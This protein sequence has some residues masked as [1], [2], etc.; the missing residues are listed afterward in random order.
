M[1][2]NVPWDHVIWPLKTL[3]YVS[4][5]CDA[6]VQEYTELFFK[7][8]LWQSLMAMVAEFKSDTFEGMNI[9]PQFTMNA[10]WVTKDEFNQPCLTRECRCVI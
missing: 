4:Q 10:I 5:T 1:Y 9:H 7:G 6:Y 3:S 8:D 2:G